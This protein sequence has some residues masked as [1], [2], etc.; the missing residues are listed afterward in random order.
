MQTGS[1][2]MAILF[3]CMIKK[4]LNKMKMVHETQVPKI[5][6]TTAVRGQK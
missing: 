1:Q 6:E 2:D 5:L 4:I 3:C